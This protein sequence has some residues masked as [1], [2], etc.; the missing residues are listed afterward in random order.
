MNPKILVID[1]ES[2]IRDILSQLLR[3]HGYE[4]VTAA[5][6]E[7]GLKAL[8][9]SF[10][11]II[12]LD[13]RLP[14]TPGTMLLDKVEQV[15]PRAKVVLITGHP[16][17]ETAIKALRKHSY[18]YIQKPFKLGQLLES[19]EGA[20]EDQRLGVEKERILEQLKFLNDMAGQMDKTMDLDAVLKQLL[21]LNMSYFKADS[22]AIYLKNDSRFVLRQHIGVTKKFIA[23]FGSLPLDHPIV[24][25][26]ANS[27]ISFAIG[28]NGDPGS[29]WAAVPLICMDRPLG[30]MVLTARSGGWFDE[31]AKRLLGIV[32]AQVG[33]TIHNSMLYS[34]AQETRDYLEGVIQNTADAIITYGLDGIVR[35]WNE[36]A[37]KIYGYR[38]DEAV[39]Q[40]FVNIPEAQ[41][42]EMSGIMRRV[43][44]GETVSNH[45]TVLRTKEE[46]SIPVDV[47]YSPVRNADGAVV[48]VS[49]IS[50][51]V[52]PPERIE[53]VPVK[54]EEPDSGTK[55]RD[56]VSALIPL[57]MRRPLPEAERRKLVALIS[58]KLERALYRD[59]L[60]DS[61][62][63]EL[64]AVGKGI[65]RDVQRPGGEVRCGGGAGPTRHHGEQMPL[66][67]RAPPQ[68][69][70]LHAHQ[71]GHHPV[72]RARLGRSA[73]ERQPDPGKPGR[74]LPGHHPPHG[75]PPI[76]RLGEAQ[77]LIF[78]S[79]TLSFEIDG[80]GSRFV[81]SAGPRGDYSRR[82]LPDMGAGHRDLP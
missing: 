20:M 23:E 36:A 45:R 22:G 66:G 50:R 16:S 68:P 1:D 12:V 74:L 75:P 63:L 41:L 21:S 42:Q 64:G 56:V 26:A 27:R 81:G 76:G 69:G 29:S 14:D 17:V 67:E 57:L 34:Q 35:T 6:A 73:S 77:S 48:A 79:L 2:G 49:S 71:G 78:I 4:V 70:Q 80:L 18:D 62:S 82:R 7:E 37:F 46:G 10:F 15:A 53:P 19:I 72:R 30:V 31:E 54:C 25:E 32:G 55:L 51:D 8:S 52:T 13:I 61:H 33:S 24:R 44:S 5:T 3:Y 58:E 65:S 9:E 11:N 28:N 38:E 43:V 60:D 39:G 40:P 47:T 59:Y